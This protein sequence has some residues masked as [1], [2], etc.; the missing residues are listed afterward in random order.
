[1][2]SRALRLASPAML[3]VLLG[4]PMIDYSPSY[5][6]TIS[7]PILMTRGA[8]RESVKAEAPRE[9]KHPGKIYSK[10]NW[11]LINERYEGVHVINN[12]NPATPLPAG[13]IAIPGCIDIAMKGN[14]LYAD[15]AVDLVAIDISDPAN[16]RVTKRI[17]NIFPELTN[18]DP[19]RTSTYDK[20][21]FIV[22]GFKDSVV[23][24][25]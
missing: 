15:N 24:V 1:M 23:K 10:A 22:V 14:V 12:T 19:W 9:L 21:K 13:F 17:E 4:C 16:V 6:Y 5:Q 8:L 18:P 25:A 11:L 2:L 20:T 7:A 3:L